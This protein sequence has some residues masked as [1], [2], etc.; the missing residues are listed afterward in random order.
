[1][2]RIISGTAR[3][4]RLQAPHGEKTRPTADRVKE[5][6]FSILQAE[7]PVDGFLDLFA[8]TGQIGLEAA[9]RGASRVVL[10]EK[11]RTCLAIIRE[12]ILRTHL[13]AQVCL[14]GQDAGRAL[15]GLAEPF[16]IIFADPPYRQCQTVTGRLAADLARLLAPGG[17]LILEHDSRDPAPSFVTNLQLERCCQYGT[18]MLSFYRRAPDGVPMLCQ[19]EKGGD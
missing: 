18:A 15:A 11:D 4:T 16:G 9:S 19:E 8:G 13:E 7:W 17:R 2:P 6:L 12:N 14:L 10:V 5:A 3:G 1:M